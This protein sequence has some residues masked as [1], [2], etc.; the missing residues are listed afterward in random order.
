MEGDS[1]EWLAALTETVQ[2]LATPAFIAKATQRVE[3]LAAERAAHVLAVAELARDPGAPGA[4]NAHHVCAVLGHALAPEDIVLN[5]A[6]RNAPAVFEQ[7]PRTQPGTLLGLPGGGLG[8]SGGMA[9][10][11]KLAR[12]DHRVVHVVGDGGFYFSNPSSL[13]SVSLQYGLPIL[14]VI[15]DNSGWA[16]VKEATLRMYPNGDAK[17]LDAFESHLAPNVDF[18][19]MA[20]AIGVYGERLDHPAEIE[21]AITRCLAAL[22]GGRTA[23]L[24]VRIAPM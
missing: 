12:R 7:I 17:R 20:E 4:L 24:H 11:Y 22:D 15:L 16:A 21:P 13:Y 5:E 10:G 3:R 18:A 2:A 1:V 23:L 8:Y 9:L 14:T 19:S 6:I